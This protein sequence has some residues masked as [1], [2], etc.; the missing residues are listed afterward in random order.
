MG[1]SSYNLA[2]TYALLRKKESALKYLEESLEKHFISEAYVKEDNDWADYLE[3]KD[4]KS[5]LAK[6]KNQD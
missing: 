4:F 3:D 1:G 5:L 2:C 6:Y